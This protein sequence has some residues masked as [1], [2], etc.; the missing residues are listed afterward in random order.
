MSRAYR[1][2]REPAKKADLFRLAFDGIFGF[3]TVPLKLATW[4]GLGRVEVASKGDLAAALRR[5]VPAGRP[6][7]R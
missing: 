2:A 1:R 7:V 3:S 5:E 4:L 6:L